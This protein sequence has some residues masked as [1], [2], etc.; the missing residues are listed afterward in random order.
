[1]SPIGTTMLTSR[2]V[3]VASCA[4]WF[5]SIMTS[6]ERPARFK[7]EVRSAAFGGGDSSDTAMT[8]SAQRFRA[9]S[10]GRLRIMPPSASTLPSRTTGEK[11]PGTAML[12]RMATEIS[13]RSSTTISP[14]SMSVDTARKGIGRSSKSSVYRAPATRLRMTSSMSCVFSRPPGAF[15]VA[16]LDA[17]I[18]AVGVGDAGQFL[19]DG[20]PVP[21]TLGADRLRPVDGEHG[22]LDLLGRH[23][24]RKGGAHQGAHAGAGHAIDRHV[25][26]VEHPEHADV[27]GALGAATA[28]H[29]ADPGA[30]ER[31]PVRG[32]GNR[33]LLNWDFGQCLEREQQRQSGQAG[34]GRGCFR[35]RLPHYGHIQTGPAT[36]CYRIH[37][38]LR[39]AASHFRTFSRAASNNRS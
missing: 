35:P 32:R 38:L 15:S 2:S 18:E 11:A 29:Q 1:M 16:V 30:A 5:A 4:V 33:R 10:T 36:V 31:R 3:R 39:L 25:Q 22:F 37:F 24:G 19:V 7:G 14:S 13:P 34:P 23:A 27:C 12:A 17:E 9:I 26:F 20:G 28:E 21:E 8:T 6:S